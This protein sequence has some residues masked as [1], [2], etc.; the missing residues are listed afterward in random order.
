MFSFYKISKAC[1]RAF[2]YSL[3]GHE[4]IHASETK[5]KG[6]AIIAS[7]HLSF[8]DP[9]LLAAS[10]DDDLYFLARSSLF[11]NPIFKSMITSL[12]AY[13]VQAS[14]SLKTATDLLQNGKKLVIFPEGTRSADGSLM[15]FKHGVGLLAIKANCPI[16][17]TYIHGTFEILPKGKIF[18]SLFHKKTACIFGAPIF[19]QE[20]KTAQMLAERAHK[21][22][23]GLKRGFSR[24]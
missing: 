10:S 5:W 6:A 7:N 24:P 16:I 2:F 14:S 8:F 12:N 9:P 19:P 22:V 20:H 23:L 17:P 15:E 1:F 11:R 21:E 13:P 18:P 3:Y 4:V